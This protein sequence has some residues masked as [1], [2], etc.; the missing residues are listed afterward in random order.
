MIAC[1]FC[2]AAGQASGASFTVTWVPGKCFDCKIAA[3]QS[4]KA[5]L[6]GRVIPAGDSQTTDGLI[7]RFILTPAAHPHV[8][9]LDRMGLSYASLTPGLDGLARSLATVSQI[10]ATCITPGHGPDWDYRV[11]Y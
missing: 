1:L 10:R 8:R 2:S 4:L 6:A 9:E 5:A 7:H 11:D 3:D